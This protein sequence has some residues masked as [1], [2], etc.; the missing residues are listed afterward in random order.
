MDLKNLYSDK[1]SLSYNPRKENVGYK[2]RNKFIAY[3]DRFLNVVKEIT[4]MINEKDSA[5]IV[6]LDIGI[7]DGIYE[8]MLEKKI[9]KKMDIYG[10]DISG[11]Q[12]DRSGKYLKE[13]R[14]VDLNTEIIPF[15]NNVFDFVLASEILEHVF[16]PDRVL[17]EAFRLLKPGGRL[18]LTFPNS[19][20]LQ[21]RLSLFLFGN[22]PLLNY[23]A[24]IEHIR[25]FNRK[26][27]LKMIG[28]NFEV[29]KYKGL[30]SL[31]FCKWNFQT[32]IIIPRFM[33]ILSNNI[34]PDL[35]LGNLLILKK[36]ET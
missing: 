5:K 24:N 18:I 11:K 20:S 8:S 22:S 26:D 7:G 10:I 25:F 34:F 13:G 36:N 17:K 31:L 14:V 33:Q 6:F 9:L 15:K 2:L 4:K 35:A 21:M 27:I 32:R 12:L 23:P 29:V 16:F 3:D 30:G 28:D 19:S 1:K